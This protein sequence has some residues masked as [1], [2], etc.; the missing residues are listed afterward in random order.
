MAV[1][2]KMGVDLSGF[3]S[4]IKQG[5]QILKGLN[6]EM[7]ASE[8]E[9][10]ATGNAEQ[11]MANKTKTLNDQIKTQKSIADQ[12]RQALDAMAKNG[13]KPT[14]EEYQKLYATMM[15]AQAGMYE[16]QAAL[17]GLGTSAQEAATGADK[18]TNSVNSIG[19]KI[20]L[21]QVISG[22]GSI[23]TGLENAAKKAVELGE[24][25]WN[26]IMDSARRADDT[27]TMAEM[28]GIDLDTFQRMQKLVAGGLD[29]TVEAILGAQTK[30]KKG[31]GT[32]SLA[33]ELE[34]IGV[35]ME[36]VVGS[37]KY[38][39]MT[40]M[41]DSVELF[42]EAGQ[43]LM[44][45]GD[46]FDKEATAQAIFGK[47]WK[48]LVPLFNQYKSLEEYNA[49]LE[50]QTVNTEETVRDLAELNDAVGKLESSW[51]TLKDELIGAI[52][53]ALTKGADSLSGLLDKLTEYLKTDEGQ[54]MLSDLGDAVAKL[55]ENITN[56]DPESVVSTFAD[57]LDK[58]TSGLE[59]IKNNS[60][61][62]EGAL[63]TIAGGFAL[64]KVS[65]TVLEF[66]KLKNGVKSLLGG[67]SGAASGAGSAAAGGA[68]SAAASG[69]SGVGVG[70]VAETALFA[71][72]F[73]LFFDGVKHDMELVSE[74]TKNAQNSIAEYQANIE[75]YSGSDMFNIWDVMTRY[76][77][78][79]GTPEDSAKMQDFAKHFFSW[80]N[81][82]ITDAGLDELA[83]AMSDEDFFAFKDAMEKILNGDT[84]YSS[85][86]QQAFADAM[87]AAIKAAEGLM[88][89]ADVKLVADPNSATDLATQVGTVKVP[90]ILVYSSPLKGY[91]NG[92]PYVPNDGL[93]KLHR[94]EQVVPAREAGRSFSSNLYV[95]NMNM[96]GGLSADALAA[97]IAARNQR[98]MSG[99]G[100]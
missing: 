43:A 76:T 73:A 96:N 4:G 70:A 10:K 93:Y 7:K 51:T 15:K 63:K 60:G 81:D 95:E 85:E 58:V 88:N 20:S 42:W 36:T 48:E 54:K 68:G 75:K 56:I 26:T 33:D 19:K 80:W 92:L 59:W 100:S 40:V 22:I 38:G 47:S 5:T 18:L 29:T 30:L 55:V 24:K 50:E 61:L 74:W 52:A 27:A 35:S 71:A 97:S 87:N 23:T 69:A 77:T 90:A 79:N 65:E 41:K 46:E 91:A 25:L 16:A 53:P 86:E 78:I 83:G 13:V 62:V 32:G 6:A 84:L 37:G 39:D 17:N 2:V 9:F 57:V 1:N 45:M 3:N 31:V 8:A 66:F 11:L 34:K 89:P 67:G 94:G 82:E 64:L 49:A 99:Y 44:S 28:Y 12:A 98:M 72:P 14:D 21:D